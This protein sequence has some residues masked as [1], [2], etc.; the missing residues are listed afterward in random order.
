MR[1]KTTQEFIQ[2]ALEI[3]GNRYNYSLTEYVNAKTKVKILCR[4]HG[5]FY[6]DPNTHLHGSGCTKCVIESRTSSLKDFIKQANII[7]QNKYNYSKSIY[8]TCMKKLIITC[9]KHGDFQQ[10]PNDH[11]CGHGC[12]KCRNDVI[13]NAKRK[14]QETYI[15]Q[16]R[17]VH[18]GKYDYS[19][20]V[21]NNA[22][23]KI[24][25]NCPEHG[26][27]IQEAASH[28]KGIGCPNCQRSLGEERIATFFNDNNIMYMSQYTYDDLIGIGG[29]H[30]RFDF[31]IPNLNLCIEYDGI[32]H[33]KCNI[34]W[35]TKKEFNTL[36]KHDKL[37]N[38]YCKENDIKLLRISYKEFE[39]IESILE[40]TLN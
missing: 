38:N 30:L 14:S 7:H 22:R 35:H 6:Q 12:I 13:G 17:N 8:T 11:L 39:N 5:S 29:N 36:Q 34:K 32:Q 4:T 20:T 25:I 3:H 40:Q 31:Y 1:K 10:K 37:K 18:N 23:S 19:F 27:F 9:P 2:Q 16:A 21:Y 26:I 33:F 28:I 24:K 15:K